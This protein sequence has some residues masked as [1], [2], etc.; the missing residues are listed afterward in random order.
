MKNS[1]IAFITSI[2]ILIIIGFTLRLC[3]T[4][5]EKQQDYR[6]ILLEI[7]FDKENRAQEIYRI[8]T[9]EGNVNLTTRSYPK[10]SNYIEIG[11]SIIKEKGKLEIVIKKKKSNY[12]TYATFPYE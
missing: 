8:Q 5:N 12:N 4:N 2:M 7:F 6:G 9:I 10:S 1:N 11:D 3:S